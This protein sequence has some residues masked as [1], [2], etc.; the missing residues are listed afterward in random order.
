[1]NLSSYYTRRRD[2]EN[3][4]TASQEEIKGYI[5][6]YFDKFFAKNS[7]D[8]L[9]NLFCYE[10]DS[11]AYMYFKVDKN[12]IKVKED[13]GKWDV[14]LPYSVKYVYREKKKEYFV[15]RDYILIFKLKPTYLI[16]VYCEIR[17][18]GV[19]GGKSQFKLRFKGSA[20]IEIEKLEQR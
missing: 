16:N 8:F 4:F 19:L 17:K 5:Y 12:K 7:N 2:F 9:R 18:G 15:D 14:V 3:S 20:A 11:S 1:M 6:D 10:K 13:S